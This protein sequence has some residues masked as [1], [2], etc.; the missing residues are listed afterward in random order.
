M[1]R[2]HTPTKE[3][4]T[5]RLDFDAESGIFTWKSLTEHDFPGRLYP[6]RDAAKHNAVNAGRIAGSLQS[7]RYIITLMTKDIRRAKLVMI[8][9]DRYVPG[10]VVDHINGNPSDDRPSNLRMSSRKENGF[11]NASLL[12]RR[13]CERRRGKWRAKVGKKRIGSYPT[14]GLAMAAMAKY[15]L[16]KHG[17]FSPFAR[18]HLTRRKPE[19]SE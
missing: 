3:E 12:N 17:K 6:K 5:A 16:M 13:F 4:I 10:K 9:T 15:S 18:K 2:T 7:G 1:A 11:N 14:K 8:M 19:T